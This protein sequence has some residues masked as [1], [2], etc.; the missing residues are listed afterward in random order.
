MLGIKFFLSFGL[1][2]F[3]CFCFT[4]GWNIAE[5][6]MSLILGRIKQAWGHRYTGSTASGKTKQILWSMYHNFEVSTNH[7]FIRTVQTQFWLH[8]CISHNKSFRKDPS[9]SIF[10]WYF[11]EEHLFFIKLEL[12]PFWLIKKEYYSLCVLQLAP[13]MHV[14][15]WTSSNQSF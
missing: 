6:I 10:W 13:L 15:N 1:I 3:S 7:S 9:L 2:I 4:L 12:M 8:I 14:F 5:S 11:A